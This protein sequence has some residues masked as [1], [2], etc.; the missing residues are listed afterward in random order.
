MMSSLENAKNFYDVISQWILIFN[1]FRESR[2]LCSWIIIIRLPLDFHAH[3][4][5][6]FL[7]NRHASAFLILLS[8]RLL[9]LATL[10][11]LEP[12]RRR[13]SPPS[14]STLAAAST[15]IDP[16]N[17]GDLRRRSVVVSVLLF[18]SQI[19]IRVSRLRR[20]LHSSL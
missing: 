18:T 9:P 19:R 12:H 11:L 6:F 4:F 17:G 15:R 5:T 2:H 20:V 3:P 7:I 13:A 8:L 10:L 16:E 14:P 1:A